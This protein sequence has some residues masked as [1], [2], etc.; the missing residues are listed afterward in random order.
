MEIREVSIK[1]IHP[2]EKNPR[3]NDNAVEAVANSIKEFGFKQPIVVDGNMEIIAGHTRWKAAKKLKLK[4]VPVLVADDLTEEQVRAYRIADNSTGELATWDYDLLMPEIAD[5]DFDM[6]MFGLDVPQEDVAIEDIVEDDYEEPE[7]LEPRVKEGE[8]WR[9]GIHRLM[10]GDSTVKADVE[11]LMDGNL[12][13]MVFTDPPWNVNYGAD[14]ND[15]HYRQRTI[16]NDKMTT[17]DFKEFMGKAFESMKS[18]LVGGGSFTL[19]CQHKSG[20]I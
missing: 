10:C 4:T 14:D 15:G 13:D 8:V 6:S 2:Y 18:A 5:L 19:S 9:L 1:D 12:A 11:I 3:I 16:L 20:V 17:E 7:N